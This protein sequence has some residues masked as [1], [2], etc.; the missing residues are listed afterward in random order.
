M[1]PDGGTRK[2]PAYILGEVI[3]DMTEITQII[4]NLGFPIFVAVWMLYKSSSDSADMRSAISELK[5]AIVVLTEKL[6]N[7]GK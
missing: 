1:R 6:H 7:D 5:E 3:M 2:N 4:G